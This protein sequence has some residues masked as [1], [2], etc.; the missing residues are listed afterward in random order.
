MTDAKPDANCATLSVGQTAQRLGVSVQT[1][2]RLIERGSLRAAWTRSHPALWSTDAQG[3]T[4][5]GWRR[6]DAGSVAAYLDSRAGGVPTK[7][8]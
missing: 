8:S 2:R 6:V 4:L 3:R 1:V 7:E 5:R